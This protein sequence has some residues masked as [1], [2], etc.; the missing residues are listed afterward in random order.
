MGMVKAKPRPFRKANIKNI[1]FLV[2][3]TLPFVIASGLWILQ[4]VYGLGLVLLLGFFLSSRLI[5]GRINALLAVKGDS[6]LVCEISNSNNWRTANPR[7]LPIGYSRRCSFKKTQMVNSESRTVIY[8]SEVSN[9]INFTQ[10]IE[11]QINLPKNFPVDA[12]FNHL[13]FEWFLE[14]RVRSKLGLKFLF[15]C[16]VQLIKLYNQPILSNSI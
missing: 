12:V 5:I 3:F 6:L 15:I 9:I 13:E 10:Q 11:A 2:L 14:I 8:E 1:G 4:L 7:Q 16:P